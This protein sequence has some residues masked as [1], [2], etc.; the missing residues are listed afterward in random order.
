MKEKD[1]DITPSCRFCEHAAAIRDGQTMLCLK[2]GA[3]SADFV[4][5][6]YAFDPLKRQ[7]RPRPKLIRMEDAE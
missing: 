4:C 6:K 2:K 5:K 7:P 3:V 1:Y